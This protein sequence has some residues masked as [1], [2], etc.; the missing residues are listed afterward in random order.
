M[1]KIRGLA[2]ISCALLSWVAADRALAVA[3]N[4]I[5]VFGDSLSDTGNV[6]LSTANTFPPSPP[7]GGVPGLHPQQYPGRFSDGQ[8]WVEY[9]AQRLGLP[10]PAPSLA[11]GTNFAWGGA[12]TG[13]SFEPYD[14]TLNPDPFPLTSTLAITEQVGAYLTSG[15][16]ADPQSTLYV[17]WGGAN[18]FVLG[19]E[20]DPAVPARNLQASIQ[21]LIRFAGAQH[22][23][24]GNMPQLTAA[25]GIGLG[26][27]SAFVSSQLPPASELNKRV[28]KFN[29]KFNQTLYKLATKNPAVSFYQLDAFAL[30]NEVLAD[31]ALFGFNNT[32]YPVLNEQ[33]LYGLAPGD[34]I[35]ANPFDSL[36]W[37]G[38]HLTTVAHS[39]LADQVFPLVSSGI[40]LDPALI[41]EPASAILL[42]AAGLGLWSRRR[43][44]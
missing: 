34:L 5:V 1:K 37:D 43:A 33:V 23:L 27:P 39:I 20:S 42:G 30:L 12:Q 31:P 40:P 13:V 38:V 19:N 10:A 17:V 32:S 3:Y 28:S 2:F 44:A 41:P 26:I 14:S 18:D 22:L 8:V 21:N 6:L 7:Y 25:P 36:F 16:I 11:G 9:L 4:Q 35:Q 15:Q 29:A 24:V